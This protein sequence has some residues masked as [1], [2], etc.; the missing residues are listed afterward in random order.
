MNTALPLE[1]SVFNLVVIS[2]MWVVFNIYY[3]HDS[4]YSTHS[5]VKK[6][7]GF[8][9]PGP[10]ENCAKKVVAKLSVEMQHAY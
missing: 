10:K 8:C 6:L 5:L 7:F 1:F 3:N 9:N 4:L 2:L